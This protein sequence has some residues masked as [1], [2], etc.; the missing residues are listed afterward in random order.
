MGVAS[1]GVNGPGWSVYGLWDVGSNVPRGHRTQALVMNV[2]GYIP[3]LSVI[4]GLFRIACG[5]AAYHQGVKAGRDEA[6][7]CRV[8]GQALLLRGFLEVCQ[9]GL[10]LGCVDVIVSSVRMYQAR[11]QQEKKEERE[12]LSVVI[13]RAP[14]EDVWWT[15]RKWVEDTSAT[16]RVRGFSN[17]HGFD[18]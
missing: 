2:L 16:K 1:G 3:V 4:C 13:V 15:P 5:V 12:P 9:L 7:F 10:A 17:V 11:Q 14:A 18:R 6:A 8:Q